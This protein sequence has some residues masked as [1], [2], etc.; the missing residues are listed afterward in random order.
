MLAISCLLC[1]LVLSRPRL[2]KRLYLVTN[3]FII[4][5]PDPGVIKIKKLTKTSDYARGILNDYDKQ[6]IN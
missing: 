1:I 2:I 3:T 5:I 4:R 6:V